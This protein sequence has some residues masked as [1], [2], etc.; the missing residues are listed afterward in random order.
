MAVKCR[1]VSRVSLCS[2]PLSGYLIN[3]GGDFVRSLS[4]KKISMML[5][6]D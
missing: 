3:G 4:D 5:I 6:G 1:F 2:L